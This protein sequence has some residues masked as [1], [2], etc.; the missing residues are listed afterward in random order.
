MACEN[1][2]WSCHVHGLIFRFSTMP[3][4]FHFFDAARVS[5][6]TGLDES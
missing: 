5:A 1:P 2:N 3:D 6:D 4:S